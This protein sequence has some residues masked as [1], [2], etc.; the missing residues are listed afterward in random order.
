MNKKFV[1]IACPYTK[2]DVAVNVHNALKVADQLVE[3]GFIP[4]V[5]IWT[6]FW[7]LVSPHPYEFWT[8]MDLEFV[9]KCDC[10][11]RIPGESKGADNE[12]AFAQSLNMPVYYSVEELEFWNDG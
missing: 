5:P 12:M 7:H 9:K 11:L 6:H 1:Y 8:E 3:L 2:G 4:Y 10:I